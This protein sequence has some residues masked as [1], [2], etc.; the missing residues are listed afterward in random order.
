MPGLDEELMKLAMRWWICNQV[1]ERYLRDEY[2]FDYKW[3]INTYG[4]LR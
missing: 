4:D 1:G 2:G 3:L